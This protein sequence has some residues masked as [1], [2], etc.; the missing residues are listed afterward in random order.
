MYKIYL[1]VNC[2]NKHM[3]HVRFSIIFNVS[4]SSVYS[5]LIFYNYSAFYTLHVMML[6]NIFLSD[7]ENL[8][9]LKNL[10]LLIRSITF[11][12]ICL[13]LYRIKITM[14]MILM[15]IYVLHVFHFNLRLKVS[16]SYIMHLDVIFVFENNADSI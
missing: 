3:F 12:S 2:V 8:I 14:L 5:I 9:Y 13:I 6:C 10:K 11:L 4:Y 1:A 15:N 16:L 7:F